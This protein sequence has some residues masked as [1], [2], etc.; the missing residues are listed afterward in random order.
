MLNLGPLA[1]TTLVYL[2]IDPARESIELV[3]RGPSAPAA[4]GSRGRHRYLWPS[5]GVPLGATASAVYRADTFPLPTGTTVFL[6]TDGLV[7][8]RGES[9]QD[10]LDRLR[11]LAKGARDVTSLC[12]RV[13][14][15]LV[16]EEP[17]DDIAFIAVR[18]PPLG[19]RL[20]T[21][22]PVTPDS[23]APIR[24]LLRRWLM[25]R[26]IA[27]QEAYDIIVAAQ[28]ACANA[29]EHAYGPGRA[30]FEVDAA[31]AEGRVTITVTDHGQWRAP[32]GGTAAAGWV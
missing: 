16:P 4:R 6:Y 25:P 5:G 20:T 30:A 2:V 29:I 19:D 22:W 1:M 8:R 9:I 32:R 26:G 23:L 17:D 21:S 28:E 11:D 12:A 7:E 24:Y 27:E 15:R 31:Y 3:E 18:V 13:V 10:G 14:E